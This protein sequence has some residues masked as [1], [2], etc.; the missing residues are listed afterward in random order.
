MRIRKSIFA[1]LLVA[2]M[3]SVAIG[4]LNNPPSVKLEIG[5]DGVPT[6]AIFMQD[7]TTP[8]IFVKANQVT[9]TT[10]LD[11]EVLVGTHTLSV[12]STSGILSGDYLGLFSLDT[13]RFY[14]LY[15][16]VPCFLRN[17]PGRT[18]YIL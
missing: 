8:A 3:A 18:V 5:P 1:A 7:Q 4:S 11:T 17:S 6:Q 14:Q 10:A 12:V 15:R 2:L 9:N 16:R 13:D